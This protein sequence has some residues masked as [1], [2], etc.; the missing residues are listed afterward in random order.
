MRG[1]SAASLEAVRTGF[2]PALRAAGGDAATLGA[3]LFAFVDALDSSGSL[4]R[5]LSDP[6]RSGADKAGLVR[7]LVGRT[8][9]PRVVT[10]LEAFA[11]GRWSREEDLVVAIETLA[12]DAV[13][14]SAQAAGLL[15]Q[16]EDE[17]FRLDR[18]LIGQRELRRAV[19]DR[20][21]TPERRENLVHGL[22]DGRLLPAT[23]QLVSRGARAPRGRTM[24]T[25]LS[26]MGR[27]AA[28]RRQRLVAEVT[29]A[30]PLS[31]AQAARLTALLER[32]YGRAVQLNVAID[33]EV[34]GGLRVQVGPEVVD[35][36]VLS[37]ID[38]AR[39]RL[40]G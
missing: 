17:L 22:L 9:D 5:A 6:A 32:S 13:L 36:T 37:R 20:A 18:V 30:A 31:A 7:G 21:A 19:T 26:L 34:L 10:V 11:G 25:M 35:S 2:E 24:S 4:R 23:V 29:S 3:Q 28:R 33:P 40:A 38:D 14:A 15:E 39:R 8:A 27:L 12:A 16:V 1:T